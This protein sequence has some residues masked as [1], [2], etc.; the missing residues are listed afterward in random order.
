MAHCSNLAIQVGI[1]TSQTIQG[2]ITFLLRYSKERPRGALFSLNNLRISIARYREATHHL[3]LEITPP[4]RKLARRKYEGVANSTANISDSLYPLSYPPTF[5]WSVISVELGH[6][7]GMTSV[8][9]VRQ[10]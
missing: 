4:F 6:R 8:E 7:V 2:P 1:Y 10:T 5:S 9:Q 3:Q